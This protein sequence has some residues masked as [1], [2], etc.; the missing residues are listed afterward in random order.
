VGDRAC[1]L[2]VYTKVGFPRA[3]ASHKSAS[4][5]DFRYFGGI[6]KS[7]SAYIGERAM[8]MIP[9]KKWCPSLACHN[10][11]GS[12][13]RTDASVTCIELISV[14]LLVRL[15]NTESGSLY[16]VPSAIIFKLVLLFKFVIVQL[17]PILKMVKLLCLQS[18]PS[19]TTDLDMSGA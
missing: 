11:K 2:L 6:F 9:R 19:A 1:G 3:H 16:N 12:A 8:R 18:H 7:R 4:G 10:V 14:I 15:V 17:S 13:G 5:S